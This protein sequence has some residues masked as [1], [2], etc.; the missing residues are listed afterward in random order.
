MIPR[1]CDDDDDDDD[2]DVVV[3]V[4][5]AAVVVVDDDDDYDGDDGDADANEVANF[6]RQVQ[7]V[8][9]FEGRKVALAAS[10]STLQHASAA[11]DA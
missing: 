5:A 1:T 7:K 11:A 9:K 10:H 6:N 2:D 3:V 4:V 8:V